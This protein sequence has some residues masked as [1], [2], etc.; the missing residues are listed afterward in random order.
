[1]DASGTVSTRIVSTGGRPAGRPGS[2]RLGLGLRLG[3]GGERRRRGGGRR[4]ATGLR[5]R[6]LGPQ[7]LVLLGQPGELGLDLVEELVTSPMS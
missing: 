4:R 1:L 6:Q 5:G 2:A 3:G 7:V